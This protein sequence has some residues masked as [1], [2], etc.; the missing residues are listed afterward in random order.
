MT[1]YEHHVCKSIHPTTGG[2]G[3]WE[4]FCNG[5]TSFFSAIQFHQLPYLPFFMLYGGVSLIGHNMANCKALVQW[6]TLHHIVVADIYAG[7]VPS[8]WD[9]ARSKDV[10]KF[11]PILEK[12]SPFVKHTWLPDAAGGILSAAIMAAFHYTLGWSLFAVWDTRV[13]A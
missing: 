1:H 2:S 6:H 3:T 9:D 4:L 5:G 7:N 11:K 8:K 10:H 12:T 13:S